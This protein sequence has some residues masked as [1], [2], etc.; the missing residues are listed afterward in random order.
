MQKTIKTVLFR[1]L[2]LALL[3]LILTLIFRGETYSV[4]IPEDDVGYIEVWD[5]NTGE[6]R[7]YSNRDD[8]RHIVSR[9]NGVVLKGGRDA[10]RS[11]NGCL[12]RITCFPSDGE[13]KEPLFRAVIKDR[14]RMQIN[15]V[16]FP[17]DAGE[18][19]DFLI[20]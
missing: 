16:T 1:L 6:I 13:E 20:P 5:G 7:S 12:C 19:L 15:E 17:F 18:L 8:I 14:N 2:F 4:E 11:E 10:D 9:L 3:I